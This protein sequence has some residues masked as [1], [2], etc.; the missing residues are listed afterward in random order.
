MAVHKRFIHFQ[1][2][3]ISLELRD[4][5]VVFQFFLGGQNHLLV[6]TNRRFNTGTFINVRAERDGFLADLRVEDDHIKA[7][8]PTNK[9]DGLELA[10]QIVYLGGV[11]PGFAF[12]SKYNITYKSLLGCLKDI[13]IDVTALDLLAKTVYLANVE[14][15][16]ATRVVRDVSFGKNAGYLKLPGRPLPADGSVTFS[17]AT[18]EGDGLLLAS[19]SNNYKSDHHY[20]TASLQSGRLVFLFNNGNAPVKL[21][22]DKYYDDRSI[23]TISIRKKKKKMAITVDDIFI[24]ELRLT[25][26]NMAILS[27]T[28]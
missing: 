1:G 4:G 5:K 9:P 25:G 10:N 18:G 27:D 7:S 14:Q 2:D 28:M 11:P 24:D 3:L 8:L 12:Q 19:M 13:Q 22:V 16:C 26:T 20:W 23:H 15:G 6:S 17:F 21:P